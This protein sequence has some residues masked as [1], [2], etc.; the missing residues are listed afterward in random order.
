MSDKV[1]YRK[2][3]IIVLVALLLLSI[4]AENVVAYNAANKDIFS[5][6][7]RGNTNA[8]ANT[9]LSRD[10]FGMSLDENIG[11][12]TDNTDSLQIV[13]G[14]NQSR[15][16]NL[17]ANEVS[18][19]TK[20][21]GHKMSNSE[22]Q[23]LKKIVGVSVEKEQR[24]EVFDGYGTGLRTPTE[25]EWNKIASD[26]II[27]DD[28]TAEALPSSIDLSQTSWFP[29][30]GNQGAQGS[31]VAWSVGYYV[32]T[33]QEAKEHGWNLSG[34]AWE[35]GSNGYPSASYQDR[36][37]SPA[38]IYNLINFG[39]DGG[40]YYLD[41]V[42]LISQVGSCSWKKMPYN[43]GD[44]VTWPS[45]DAW[46]E[47]SLYRGN[48]SGIVYLSTNSDDGINNLKNWLSMG[49]LATI[50]VDASFYSS[51]TSSD[52]WTTDNYLATSTN[53]ANTVVG[54]DD[55][56]AYMEDGVMKFGA[57]KVANSW[58]VG[59]SGEK[60]P[61]GFYWLSY[62]AMKLRMQYS[63][64]YGDKVGYKPELAASF[65]IDHPLRGECMIT[66]GMGTPT[67]PIAVKT[68]YEIHGGA[69]P[70]CQNNI[71]IDITEFKNLTP[72][73]YDQSFFLSVDDLDTV[74][75]GT[76]SRFS[77]ESIDCSNVPVQTI[78]DNTVILNLDLSY[79]ETVWSEK[80]IVN[81]DSDDRDGK[82]AS[83]SDNQGN[84]FCAYVDY[85]S[86]N[87]FKSI[88]VKKS[89]DG[90]QSWDLIV[91]GLDAYNL[92][93]PSIAIDPA[94]N[95]IYVVVEREYASNDHDILALCRVDSS[96]SWHIIAAIVG[97]DDRFPSITCEYQYGSGNWVYV[98]YEYVYNNDDR[99][100]MFASS[101]DCG[102]TWSTT[103]LN[104]N[105]PDGNVYAQTS[106]TNAEGYL[107][108]A[109]KYGADY[110]SICD[111]Y[112]KQSA[113]FGNSW[114][115]YSN[116]DGLPNS[117]QHPSIA[118]THG[119]SNV[120]VA[121]EYQLSSGG[122]EVW[123]ST[124]SDRGQS[125]IKGL[126][127][128]IGGNEASVELAVD[129]EGTTLTD[130]GG[131][132]HALCKDGRF[133]KYR[134]IT[135]GSWTNPQIISDSWIGGGL[136]ISTRLISGVSSPFAVW[137][138]VRNKNAYSSCFEEKYTLI[139]YTNPTNAGS[140]I[141]N[142][143]SKT[144]GQTGEYMQGTYSINTSPNSNYIFD[145]WVTT[146]DVN[147]GAPEHSSTTLTITDSGSLE[148][149]FYQP[150]III[151]ADGSV[152]PAGAPIYREENYYTLTEDI[153]YSPPEADS[154]AIVIQKDDIV[155][156]GNHHIVTGDGIGHGVL[157]EGRNN[158]TVANL[159]IN[160]FQYC[161]DLSSSSNTLIHSNNL[162]GGV[163]IWLSNSNFNVIMLNNITD[164]YY[165][166]V[167]IHSSST[168]NNISS[169]NITGSYFGISVTSSAIYNTISGNNITN[170]TYG[171]EV[172]ASNNTFS[173]N[174]IENNVYGVCCLTD[175]YGNNFYHNNFA[176]NIQQVIFP[177]QLPPGL[178]NWDDG[179]PSGG[180]FWSDYAGVDANHDGIGDTPYVI[181]EN[182][183]DNYPL[184]E[185][186]DGQTSPSAYLVVRGSNN[187]IYCRTLNTTTD[188]WSGWTGLS[189]QTQ[190]PPAAFKIGNELHIVVRG[191]NN[192]QIWH[193]HVNLDTDA[194]SGWSL[195]DGSTPSPPILTGNSTHLCLVVRGTNNAIYYRFYT[196][197]SR[198]WSSWMTMPNGA[199]V[200]TPAA[201]LVGD[202][203]HIVV[204]G[205]SGV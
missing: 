126:S 87:I 205:A 159:T 127:L 34:S 41:A 80:S 17:D 88:F 60:V 147:V 203:L 134:E 121:F 154:N 113:D 6:A 164:N 195:L 122:T 182:N 71:I 81:F 52:V 167:D 53:H 93:Y 198:V 153:Y 92:D 16:S 10:E 172:G 177:E 123:C 7:I 180:N 119:G 143:Q 75:T 37:I 1:N 104:G 166:G 33:Y 124:S 184:M 13:L 96:W 171:V 24:N 120:L 174:Y 32:K 40:S 141:F 39:E 175:C 67:T 19:Q 84:L 62:G 25:Q 192:G 199:T 115:Q 128:F 50:A 18:S 90:G 183:Q 101:T 55:N 118:A 117:C 106:I 194:W 137:T 68:L 35:G 5:D 135:D 99:D 94:N 197:A 111:I 76:V 83:A 188:V 51:L 151:L 168:N 125:W 43:V 138:D 108:L 170:N 73:V 97:S 49:N 142:G 146:G 20:T 30:I 23:D 54:Y 191:V 46:I 103:K 28:V 26:A 57:F 157:L 21:N 56:F 136:D 160:E 65:R 44:F 110:G 107:Y 163:G 109:Y 155:F 202:S 139:F 178:Y 31:C 86:G 148:A 58:G 116:V 130:I 189:G 200:D 4:I 186:W 132:F 48:E 112:V 29:P 105:W 173:E 156:D 74:A 89:I 36:I 91:E 158:L 196:L 22:L 201:S 47:A 45:E 12:F 95:N 69:H 204:R 72:S 42:N 98:S 129:G 100:L 3:V 131:S 193:G 150:A 64:V 161:L 140:I 66:L 85:D 82:V 176:S 11:V 190:T 187:V 38:F 8:K 77:I 79:L 78:N 149:M 14:Q 27:V 165:Y 185:S 179:Y 15:L 181:D 145:H 63:M 59:F 70:F 114:T 152:E 169:N 102:F 9:L 162:D 61:D 144:N 133:A 2:T